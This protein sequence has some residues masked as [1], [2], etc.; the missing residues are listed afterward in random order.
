MNSSLINA[1]WSNIVFLNY[2]IDPKLLDRFIP[3]GVELDYFEDKCFVSVIGLNFSNI[4]ILG[5]PDPIHPSFPEI[6]FRFYV[7]RKI[8]SEIRKGVVFI[9]EYISRP[10]LAG[11]AK[12]LFGE[13]YAVSEVEYLQIGQ[14]ISYVVN[15]DRKN[16]FSIIKDSI[17]TQNYSDIE[18]F[19]I[20]R[21]WGYSQHFLLGSL[22][23]HVEH[24]HWQIFPIANYKIAYHFD[25]LYSKEFEFLNDEKPFSVY[26][27]EG[28]QISINMRGKIH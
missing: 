8:G 26:F 13:N 17:P 2:E 11:A 4:K 23:Y 20:N 14:N 21:P 25:I 10:I 15:K 1:I 18:E 28:S 22:E 16:S 27:L 3:K 5:V 7:K 19:L 6:N 9:K 24:P 12:L